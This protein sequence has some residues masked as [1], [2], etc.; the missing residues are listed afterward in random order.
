MRRRTF[1]NSK[2]RRKSR[3]LKGGACPPG[4]PQR[5][6]QKHEE[7]MKRNKYRVTRNFKLNLEQ[8][9]R[10][11]ERRLMPEEERVAQAR[12]A[13]NWKSSVPRFKA[14]RSGEVHE[15]N[16][17]FDNENVHEATNLNFPEPTGQPAAFNTIT[18]PPPLEAMRRRIYKNNNNI[19]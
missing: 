19:Y 7:K 3:S 18:G 11:R 15:N 9:L 10:N 8:A 12:A 6:C 2:G 14:I 4:M 16:I 13:F 17:K 1:R 5:L